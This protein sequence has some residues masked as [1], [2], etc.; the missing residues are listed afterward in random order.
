VHIVHAGGEQS[1]AEIY[2]KDTARYERELAECRTRVPA[3]IPENQRER[4]AQA[5]WSTERIHAAG[6]IAIFPHPFWRP[7]D[8]HCYNVCDSLTRAFLCSGMFDA[9][10][11]VG[12]MKVHGINRAVALWQELRCEGHRISVV[13]SSDVHKI[14]GLDF[15]NHFTVC[16]AKANTTQEILQSVREGMSVA[17]ELSGREEEREFR[18]YGDFRLVSYAQFLLRFYFPEWERICRGEGVAMRRYAMGQ[19]P[20]ATLE[21]QVAQS[22]DF[23]DTFFGKKAPVLP[24]NEMLALEDAWR[25]VQLDGPRSKGSLVFQDPPTLQI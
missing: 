1:V 18:A 19:T 12:G 20:A 15:P 17:V 24:D 21:A 23:R 8:N 9:F 6:G 25:A 11:L 3:E 2:C 10:E 13:G 5:I 16:F 7:G 4:Y 14:A 22:M